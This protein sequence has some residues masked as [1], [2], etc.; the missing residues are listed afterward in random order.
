MTAIGLRPATT[1][2][3][4]YCFQLHRAAMGAY[5]TQIWGW[6]EHVQRDFHTGAF[7][8]GRWQIITADGS[9]VGMLHVE[10]R[11]TEI[12]LARIE[13]HPDHQERGIGSHLMRTLLHQARQQDRD[14]TLDVL[15]V[16]QRAQALYR[17]LGL[18]EVTRHGE[19]DI[20]IRMSTKQPLSG[21]IHGS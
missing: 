1:A 15:V 12:Y 11:P 4:E 7:S 17:R 16:N 13:L 6:D 5:I 10:H 19:N 18:H 14:L 9:E 8:P 21:P 3:S 2:D 20:K